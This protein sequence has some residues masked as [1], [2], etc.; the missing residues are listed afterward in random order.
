MTYNDKY[1]NI[2]NEINCFENLINNSE[3][4]CC[5]PCNSARQC[6]R[7]LYSIIMYNKDNIDYLYNNCTSKND[8]ESALELK[9][10]NSEV[11]NNIQDIYNK[12]DLFPNKTEV[13][14]L[15]DEKASK[16]ELENLNNNTP[17]LNELKKII[18][19]DNFQDDLK[20]KLKNTFI[21]KNDFNEIINTKANKEI[22]IN[23]L[24]KKANKSDIENIIKNINDKIKED[25]KNLNE[26]IENT[27][28]KLKNE[29]KEIDDNIIKLKTNNKTNEENNNFLKNNIYENNNS[30]IQLNDK[31]RELNLIL[32][33]EICNLKENLCLINKE[34]SN[35]VL[36]LNDYKKIT[37]QFN[38]IENI[39]N[40]NKLITYNDL[41]INS[42]NL[43]NKIKKDLLEFENFIKNYIKNFENDF[44][45]KFKN[46]NNSKINFNELYSDYCNEKINKEI[47]KIRCDLE[48]KLNKNELDNYTCNY[49]DKLSKE[50]LNKVD[51]ER[52]DSYINDIKAQLN[53]LKNEIMLKANITELTNYIK[54]IPNFE[55]INKI[56]NSFQNNLNNKSNT[57]DL[58]Q[59]I[60]SQNNINSLLFNNN[61]I[62]K[63]IWNSTNL[64]N[65]FIQWDKEVINNC[66][67]NIILDNENNVQIIINL[68]GIYN[69]VLGIYSLNDPTIDI[70]LN[71]ENILTKNKKDLIK[72]ELNDN[73]YELL[74]KEKIYF[75]YGLTL[76]EFLYLNEKSRLSIL[77]SGD[78][79]VSGFLSI[80]KII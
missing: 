62:A 59:F 76:N 41:E 71:G 7:Y 63:Y 32:N 60:D 11:N 2:Y 55:E 34:L 28:N 43:H 20:E 27:N 17:K 8:L 44:I 15:L 50:Y 39:L 31:I 29:I 12:L 52:F 67:E 24:H 51:Y 4:W 69:I 70:Y 45:L 75:Y 47:M 6:L 33:N 40:K 73:T 49:F 72:H 19:D 48:N 79:N 35:N 68:K 46:D 42:N 3:Q 78:K 9:A 53:N 54:N 66:K 77:Y 37:S 58:I 65:N 64:K 61:L 30:I 56:L 1:A 74:N 5:N 26:I 57:N 13:Q 14:N 80:K 38:E 36:T 18:L 16:N 25:N 23:S 22:V 21:N 10:D